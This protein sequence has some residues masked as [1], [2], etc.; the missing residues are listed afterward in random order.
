MGT[1]SPFGS[2]RLSKTIVRHPPFPRRPVGSTS[3]TFP[4]IRRPSGKTSVSSTATGSTKVVSTRSPT[5]E[6][7]EL[8]VAC[9]RNL[10]GV[11]SGMRN[12]AAIRVSS[13]RSAS[14]CAGQTN[15]SDAPNALRV[16]ALVRILTVRELF[17][18]IYHAIR[19]KSSSQGGFD[20][21]DRTQ[22]RVNAGVS[23]SSQD[24]REKWE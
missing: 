4:P 13:P 1:F 21:R 15:S 12:S 20:S 16:L 7:L 24:A 19:A 14:R 5:L 6:V 2:S 8:M 22:R 9:K 10:K 3:A 11:P 18:R 17:L 23:Q